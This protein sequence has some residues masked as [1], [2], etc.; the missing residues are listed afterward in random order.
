VWA[1]GAARAFPA[2]GDE[3]GEEARDTGRAWRLHVGGLA[4]GEEAGRPGDVGR[5]RA[6]ALVAR[7]EGGVQSDRGCSSPEQGGPARADPRPVP[8]HDAAAL[9]DADGRLERRP[10]DVPDVPMPQPGS[11]TTLPRPDEGAEDAGGR[12]QDPPHRGEQEVAE[13]PGAGVAHES[14]ARSR[15]RQSDSTTCA[16]ANR[17]SFA[18]TSVHGASTVLVRAIMSDTASS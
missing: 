8:D 18:A 5:F 4:E 10:R 12:R 1:G 11:G 2:S 13:P 17:L 7:A 9:G 15:R 3:V 6:R 14:R 16:R